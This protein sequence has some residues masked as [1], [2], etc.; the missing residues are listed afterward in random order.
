MRTVEA[1]LAHWHQ[2]YKDLGDAER[3][4]T[5]DAARPADGRARPELQAEV[6]RLK[7]ECEAAF[8][9]LHGLLE[10]RKVPGSGVAAR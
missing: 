6:A 10:Q 7:R 5:Q 1:K 3:R 4:L 8:N 9:A 2:L